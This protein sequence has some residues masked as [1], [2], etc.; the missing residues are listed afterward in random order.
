M[1]SLPGQG[2]I[3]GGSVL[4]HK[5]LRRFGDGATTERPTDRQLGR[6]DAK[7]GRHFPNDVLE[8]ETRRS[9]PHGLNPRD[10]VLLSHHRKHRRRRRFYGHRNDEGRQDRPQGDIRGHVG[11]RSLDYTDTPT[12]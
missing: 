1:S 6:T 2:R 5:S 9:T 3:Y 12:D 7:R 10:A 11:R 4:T 8:S